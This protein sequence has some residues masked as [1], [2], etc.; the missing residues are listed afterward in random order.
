MKKILC[1]ILGHKVSVPTAGVEYCERCHDH[2]AYY[3]DGSQWTDDEREGIVGPLRDLWYRLRRW[4]VPRCDH[5]GKS[6]LFRKRVAH[7]FCSR[8]CHNKWLPF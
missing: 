7:D 1:R 6:L 8:E 5:C 2:A 4:T 3:L